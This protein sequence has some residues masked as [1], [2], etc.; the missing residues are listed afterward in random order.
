MQICNIYNTLYIHLYALK[1]CLMVGGA[2]KYWEFG[3]CKCKLLY[4]GWINSKALLYSTGNYIQYLVINHN[5]KNYEKECV[6]IYVCVCVC[7][8]YWIISIKNN[9]SSLEKKKLGIN[10]MVSIVVF[11]AFIV[12]FLIPNKI[13]LLASY[14]PPLHSWSLPSQLHQ[15]V[16]FSLRHLWQIQPTW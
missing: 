5:E 14:S 12:S 2:R 10:K 6:Y 11:S 15:W 9:E 16:L 7:V 1:G 3:I 4:I 13:L 8:Y